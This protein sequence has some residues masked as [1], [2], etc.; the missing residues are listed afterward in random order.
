MN[1]FTYAFIHI[2]IRILISLSKNILAINNLL[3]EQ[4][5]L[6]SLINILF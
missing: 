5:K 2:H 3:P 6:Y 4:S 1:L